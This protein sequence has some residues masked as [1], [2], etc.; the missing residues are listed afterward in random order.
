MFDWKELQAKR[1]VPPDDVA[2]WYA[3]LDQIDTAFIK[4]ILSADEQ[5]RAGRYL[6]SEAGKRFII[7]RGILRMALGKYLSV[8]PASLLFSYT[9]FGKP[10]LVGQDRNSLDFNLS[11]SGNLL[12]VAVSQNR[13]VGIDLEWINPDIDSR[14]AASIVFST[15]EIEYLHQSGYQ[16]GNFYE[17]WTRKEAVLKAMGAGFSYPARKFSVISSKQ[18]TFLTWISGDVTKGNHCNLV[19]FSPFG[20]YA[21]ALATI[22]Q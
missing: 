18:Q 12:L 17:I 11:H 13:K 21:G 3:W 5:V 4:N 19:Q 1:D 20:G 22:N 9:R 15:Q 16:P 8:N 6:N 2:I 14:A 10:V 7:G